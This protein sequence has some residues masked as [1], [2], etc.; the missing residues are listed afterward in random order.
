MAYLVF[1]YYFLIQYSLELCKRLLKAGMHGGQ[2]SGMG[3][4]RTQSNNAAQDGN[5]VRVEAGLLFTQRVL[6]PAGTQEGDPNFCFKYPYSIS[7]S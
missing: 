2:C 6:Q 3:F 5:R 1:Y 7:K 4:P